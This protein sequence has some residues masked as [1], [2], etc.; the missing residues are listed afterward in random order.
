MLRIEEEDDPQSGSLSARIIWEDN[1]NGG[2]GR[3]TALTTDGEYLYARSDEDTGDEDERRY[4]I[5]PF[6]VEADGADD[7]ILGTVYS[8]LSENIEKRTDMQGA[9]DGLYFWTTGDEADPGGPPTSIRLTSTERQARRF[10]RVDET[11]KIRR[12]FHNT[13]VPEG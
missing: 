2:T 5:D 7:P 12:P 10:M 9:A 13:L 8:R 6:S 1:Q 3:I 4:V 11:S